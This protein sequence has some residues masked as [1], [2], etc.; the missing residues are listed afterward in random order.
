MEKLKILDA[1]AYEWLAS[2]DPKHWS[3]AFFY[4]FCSW[5]ILLNNL[6][7]VFNATILEAIDKPIITCMD[8]IRRYISKRLVS[9]K[10]SVEKWH[11]DTRPRVFKIL[12]KNKLESVNSIRDYCGD[13]KFE[14]TPYCVAQFR[15]DLSARTCDCNSFSMHSQPR[16]PTY[17]LCRQML[18][19]GDNF[20]GIWD[21]H[22]A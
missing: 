15:V 9:R 19:E 6:C 21:I 7:E 20:K 10:E 22:A 8:I 4:T 16:S 14:V 18:Q 2:R 5:N 17:G 3:R 1:Q 11:H 13:N 12:E